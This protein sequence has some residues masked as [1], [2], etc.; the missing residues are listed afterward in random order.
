MRQ[1]T[2]AKSISNANYSPCE[3][4]IAGHHVIILCNYAV[5]PHLE[6]I[7]PSLRMRKISGGKDIVAVYR[8]SSNERNCAYSN[9][10]RRTIRNPKRTPTANT[11]IKT[12]EPAMLTAVASSLSQG[13]SRNATK[14]LR[15]LEQRATPQVQEKYSYSQHTRSICYQVPIIIVTVYH[16]IARPSNCA[17]SNDEWHAAT[18][19]SPMTVTHPPIY[20]SGKLSNVASPMSHFPS[21][22]A[23]KQLCPLKL[24]ATLRL[25]ELS[26][27]I[28][29]A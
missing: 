23:T 24:R 15:S 2:F 26:H 6:K 16:R 27:N 8:H 14:K 1:N 4:D 10:R 7:H 19:A 3:Q 21:R 5:T 20:K 25:P 28:Y 29:F 22:S 12:Y 11:Y 17:L 18:S 13:P 9:N